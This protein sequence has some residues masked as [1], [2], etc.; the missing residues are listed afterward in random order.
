MTYLR[1]NGIAID[2][3]PDDDEVWFSLD[4]MGTWIPNKDN[5]INEIEDECLKVHN[6]LAANIFGD[7]VTYYA[8]IASNQGLLDLLEYAGLNSE[9]P[10]SKIDFESI[11][12]TKLNHSMVH[13]LLYLYD[14]RKLVSSIQE[15]SKELVHIQG[16]FYKTLNLEPLFYPAIQ[17]PDGTRYITSAT[18]TKLH[19]LIG[20]LYI[21]MHSMLDYTTKLAFEVDHLRDS[22]ETYPKLSSSNI[23]FSDK[24]RISIN[25]MAGT[26]FETNKLIT[27]IEVFR[28]LI[29]HN[30]LLDDLPKAYKVVKDG[31]DIEK[32]ILMPDR[33]EN[34]H[35]EKYKNRNLFYSKEDK[36]NLRLTGLISDFQIKMAKT[37]ADINQ[38]LVDKQNQEV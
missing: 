34:G 28:N 35:L 6:N 29:I 5:F 31:V 33:S 38:I 4:G 36:I 13:Q 24:S 27:E 26:V 2:V 7:L 21:R 32:F 12:G 17:E 8:I 16:E 14:C 10:I 30:G 1:K 3:P 11:I 37:L 20:F 19:L 23:Q 22:F 25:N 15:C 9:S 18:T